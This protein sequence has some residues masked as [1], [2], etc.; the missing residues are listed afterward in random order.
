MKKTITILLLL[1][2]SIV[3]V[4]AYTELYDGACGYGSVYGNSHFGDISIGNIETYWSRA[5]Y[6]VGWIYYADDNSTYMGVADTQDITEVDC[7][8]VELHGKDPDGTR[9][10]LTVPT[11]QILCLYRDG[12]Y[13]ALVPI[14]QTFDET[15]P[16]YMVYTWYFNDGGSSTFNGE[17]E[18][19]PICNDEMDEGQDPYVYGETSGLNYLGVITD[20]DYDVCNQNTLD[21]KYCENNIVK[22][23]NIHCG[24]GCNEEEGVCKEP[25]DII[26]KPL[27]L[28]EGWNLIPMGAGIMPNI[29]SDFEDILNA[30]YV[31]NPYE[32]KFYDL[33][34]DDDA[35]EELIEETGF[36]AVWV[37]I[38]E[39]YVTEIAINE[40][41][42]HEAVQ[43]VDFIFPEGWNFYVLIPELQKS[44]DNGYFR[45]FED[46][47]GESAIKQDRVFAWSNREKTWES[48]SY[49][50]ILE[51]IDEMDELIGL[52][53]IMKYTDNL[54]PR[55]LPKGDLTLPDFP[56]LYPR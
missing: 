52:P 11:N 20:D 33:L 37:Y 47:H 31:Y 35:L 46:K 42:I 43:E 16:D 5:T 39:D 12:N 48:E 2:A 10:A 22:S 32:K 1:I 23:I 55:F 44:N 41:I 56:D 50:Y 3:S 13:G 51:G 14:E 36:A 9:N 15:Y 25:S 45:I 17:C 54:E 49:T 30:A 4:E 53:I 8:A 21:E 40:D 24:D 6:Q 38:T 29:D 26:V 28:Y 7:Q 27:E 19:L 34:E 18:V